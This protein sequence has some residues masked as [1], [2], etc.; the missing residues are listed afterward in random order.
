MPPQRIETHAA[1]LGAYLVED[2]WLL[3][4]AE[5]CVDCDS[6]TIMHVSRVR[7]SEDRHERGIWNL[8]LAGRVGI[9]DAESLVG[10]VE[11]RFP[12]LPLMQRNA[13]QDAVQQFKTGQISRLRHYLV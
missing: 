5:R 12:T 9:V 1:M 4:D 13:Y 11:R 3:K 8:L 10:N 6:R 2:G 7:R